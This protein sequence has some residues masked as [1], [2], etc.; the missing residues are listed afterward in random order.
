MAVPRKGL[1]LDAES[2]KASADKLQGFL[3][4][5][6]ALRLDVQQ[7]HWNIQG[8]RFYGVHTM[9]GTFYEAL[10]AEVDEIAERILALGHPADGRPDKVAE[11]TVVP[12]AKEGFVTVD[13][14]LRHLLTQYAAFDTASEDVRAAME[15][16]DA[17]THDMI[18]HVLEVSQKQQ[19]MIRSHLT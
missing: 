13:E 10:N 11:R 12:G 7:V 18:V 14:G 19:W 5:L 17:V 9:L 4:N 1:P 16:L 15:E 6:I 3:Y 8:S 2:R